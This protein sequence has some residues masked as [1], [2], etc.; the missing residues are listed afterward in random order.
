[1]WSWCHHHVQQTSHLPP[2]TPLTPFNRSSNTAILN[3]TLLLLLPH[4]LTSKHQILPFWPKASTHKSLRGLF[5]PKRICWPYLSRKA[6]FLEYYFVFFSIIIFALG[7]LYSHVHGHFRKSPHYVCVFNPIAHLFSRRSC[8][9]RKLVIAV[10]QDALTHRFHYC[11]FTLHIPGWPTY[12][13]SQ[14]HVQVNLQF[15]PCPETTYFF[16][17]LPLICLHRVPT[18]C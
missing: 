1:M 16:G 14:K 5:W 4:P 2:L 10:L 13:H 17:H 7:A 3:H 6:L 8:E 9:F 15:I 11:S 12:I 18:C